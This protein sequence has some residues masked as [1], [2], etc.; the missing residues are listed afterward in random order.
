MAI[1]SVFVASQ[2]VQV[3]SFVPVSLQVGS[4]VTTPSFQT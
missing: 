1:G 3:K 4:F 2:T